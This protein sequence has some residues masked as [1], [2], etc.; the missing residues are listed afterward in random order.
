MKSA[1]DPAE[2]GAPATPA[3]RP[4]YTV[5]S[6]G[7]MRIA[8]P[9]MLASMSTP[10]VGAVDTAVVGQL[11]E[12]ALIGGV[13]AAVI[14]MNFVF[15]T[16]NFLRT[17][18]TAMVA[19]A[20]GANDPT[21]MAA[22]ALRAGCLAMGFGALAVAL[23]WPL[24][25]LGLGL[26]GIE[27]AVREAGLDYFGVRVWSAPFMLFNYAMV[28]WLFG[29]G[30][31][32]RGL[33]LQVLLNLIHIALSILFVAYLG[34]GVRGAATAAV[35]A[36][37]ITALAGAT[38]M[39]RALRGRASIVFAAVPDAAKI[40]RMLVV[41]V[42]ILIR[43]LLLFFAVAFFTRQGAAFG[44]TILAANVVLMNLFY[45]GGAAMDGFATAAQ[46]LAGRSVGARDRTQFERTVIRTIAWGLAIG[47]TM[48]G[49]YFLG[50]DWIIDTMTASVEVRDTARAHFHWVVVSAPLGAVP[51]VMDGIFIGATWSKDM[52]NMMLLSALCFLGAS[53]ALTPVLGNHGL[54][55][56]LLLFLT[57]RG[58][59][60]VWR[61]WRLVPRTFPAA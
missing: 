60:L 22:T 39:A 44:T 14:V 1:I 24:A 61:M 5:T 45:L 8:L 55:I 49:I 34:W 35:I 2:P 18:T 30:A 28:G 32:F 59:T 13:A 4:R 58:A 56:A 46:Q 36:E 16:F 17:S 25:H 42:D 48:A 3:A 6:A 23:Q 26:L 41:N 40:R 37:S 57:A 19:Q 54:W 21:E 53:F 47:C 9:V 43:S 11:G 27:G 7:V 29:Q 38:L 12:P 50:R 33:A 51:F 52:R 15:F 31:V 20:L 10:L